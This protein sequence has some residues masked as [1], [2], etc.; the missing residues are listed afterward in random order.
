MYDERGPITLSGV[1]S[2]ARSLLRVLRHRDF[3]LLWLANTTSTVGDRIV[4]VALALFV[5]RLTGSPSDLGLVIAAYLLPLIGFMLLGG[6]LAD[7]MPRHLVVVVTDLVRFALH[8]L[9]ALLIVSGAVR[10]WHLVAI[11]IL[12]GSAEAFY[13]PAATGLLPQTVPEDEI[14]EANALTSMSACVAVFA[15]PALATLLV[16]GVGPAAAFGLDAATFLVS[17]ALLVRVHPRERGAPARKDDVPASVLADLRDGYAEVRSRSWVWVTLAVFCV[18]LFVY[19]APLIVVG[20]IVAQERYG[21]IAVYG[22]ILAA[23]GAGTIAGSIVALRWRP[24]HPL[25]RAMTLILLWPA[26]VVPFAAG[27]PLAVV[28]PAM[29]V[30]GWGIALF[31][32]WWL[33]ALAERIPPDKLSRVTSYD[34]AVSLGLMP[35]GCVLAG[36]LAGVLGATDLLLGGSLVAFGVLALGLL[37]RETRMLERLDERETTAVA[38]AGAPAGAPLA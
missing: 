18:A 20:P 16:L 38:I 29:V 21:E 34:W 36:P 13:R 31:E 4:T 6:V 5:V 14:Q 8:G 25:R 10:I 9:L 23:L 27:A 26:A 7:R 19:E 1:M 30:A 32:V 35:L 3:R 17:A 37:P 2:T 15:G 22:Y 28:L 33:T 24:R 12:F 11:G